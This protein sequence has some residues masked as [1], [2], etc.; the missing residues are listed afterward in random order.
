MTTTT[1]TPTP[2]TLSHC[3][4]TFADGTTGLHPLDLTIDAGETLVLLGPS[5]CGKTTTLRLIAGLEAPDEGGSIHFGDEDVTHQPVEKRDVGIV[6]QHYAL[7]PNMDVS[8]NITYGLK[9]RR[10]SKAE[11][12]QRLEDMLA[13]LDL[14][15]LANRP[16]H[17][18][19]GGQRQRV[20]LARALIIQPRVL[21]FDEPL[22]ALDAQLRERL[23]EDIAALLKRL[24]ITAVYVTHDQEEAMVVGDRIA[25]LNQGRIVQIGSARDLYHHPNSTF[26]ADF[27]GNINRL[28]GQWQDGAFHTA[29]GIIPASSRSEQ[30][31]DTLYC[32]PEHITITAPEQ[33]QLTGTIVLNHY[34]GHK[35][36]L[37]IDIGAEQ[38]VIVDS[39]RSIEHPEGSR[40]GLSIQPDSAYSI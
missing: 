14:A 38:T 4:R 16:I 39:M 17:A 5:G 29:G 6:F 2:V 24:A 32:R 36:R 31:G 40:V 18:L 30:S 25:L 23:R 27:I 33:G 13:M 15:H 22:S 35:Q 1:S 34:L 21:L 10:M 9:F 7:F 20:A 11:K 28:Q 37:L 3:A 8:K 26:S 19:S 12:Q